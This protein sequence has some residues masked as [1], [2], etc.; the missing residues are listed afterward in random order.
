MDDSVLSIGIYEMAVGKTTLAMHNEIASVLKLDISFENDDRKR[1]AKLSQAFKKRERFV[2]MLDNVMKQID[3]ED[4]GISVGMNGCKL[5]IT[6]QSEEVYQWMVPEDYKSKNTPPSR[7]FGTNLEE[8][9]Q[10]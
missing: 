10:S 1:A 6:T 3:L 4:I 8:T 5:V 2:L 7:S 9:S